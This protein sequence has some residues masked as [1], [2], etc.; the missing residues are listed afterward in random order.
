MN[1]KERYKAIYNNLYTIDERKELVAEAIKR[2][3][4]KE[5]ITQKEVAEIIN[6]SLATYN[7]YETGRNATPLEIVVRLAHLYNID[8]ALL[9]QFDNFNKDKM[10]QQNKLE[11]YEKQ[12]AEL[13][14]K[15][16]QANPEEQERINQFILGIE[17][18]LNALK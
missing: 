9:L 13:K 14:E 5:G 16:K 2:F 10:I 17:Q 8:P 11:E 4:I 12:I 18:M 6:I 15:V 3:R 1:M 7:S